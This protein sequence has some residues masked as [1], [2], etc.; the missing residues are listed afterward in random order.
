MNVI[1]QGGLTVAAKKT[2]EGTDGRYSLSSGR[3]VNSNKQLLQ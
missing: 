1:A 3:D 2:P